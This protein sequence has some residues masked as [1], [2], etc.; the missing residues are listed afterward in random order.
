MD[1]FDDWFDAD[2]GDV[3][4]RDVRA[5]FCR[6]AAEQLVKRAGIAQPPV[7]VDEIAALLGF[8][9]R[10][11]AL[12]RGLD[13]RALVTGD[14]K[15]IELDARAATVRQR[16]SIAHELGHMCLGHAH[17]DGPIAERQ[18]NVFAGSLLVPRKW[19]T[20]DIKTFPTIE[21]L[22][23]RYHVSRDVMTIALT[24]ARLLDQLR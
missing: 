1:R 14:Q 22:A 15:I 6:K 11:V 8:N 21:A 7:P 5:P 24:D 4:A 3:G 2:R 10:R 16:F 17:D 18:A 9:V 23:Q 13:A 19:L 12:P 20:R